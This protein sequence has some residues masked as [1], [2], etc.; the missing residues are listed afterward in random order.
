ML[1][2]LYQIY[3]NSDFNFQSK[4]ILLLVNVYKSYG[5]LNY[6]NK[7]NLNNKKQNESHSNRDI[8][9]DICRFS[10]SMYFFIFIWY[11]I[12]VYVDIW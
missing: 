5:W 9:S 1:T 6:E 12:C 8:D 2:F 3:R 4:S 11:L 10:I 7:I